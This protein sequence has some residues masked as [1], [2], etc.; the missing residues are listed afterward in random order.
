MGLDQL[1]G[2]D[3]PDNKGGRP[4]KEEQ[5]T[6]RSRTPDGDPLTIKTDREDWINHK[7]NVHLGDTEDEDEDEAIISMANELHVHPIVIRKRLEQYDIYETDWEKY[8]EKYPMYKKDL[9]IRGRLEKAGVDTPSTGSSSGVSSD[10]DRI[11]DDVDTS[12]SS[13]EDDD[14][15]SGLSSM[16]EDT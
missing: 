8:I 14:M 12:S 5:E 9:R 2:M 3:T 6:K 1:D 4:P 16:I 7:F 15:S 13:S 11:F 10:L